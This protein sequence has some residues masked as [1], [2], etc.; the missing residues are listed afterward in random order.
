[1]PTPTLDDRLRAA[2]F[3]HVTKLQAAGGGLVTGEQLNKGMQFEGSRVPIWSEPRG[4]YKPALLGRHGAALTIVTT[5]PRPGRTP[6]YDDDV[7]SDNDYIIYRYR[8]TDPLAYDNRALRMAFAE[9]RPLLYLRGV[10]PGVYVPLFPVFIISD[11]PVHLTCHVS[12]G[13]PATVR[14]PLHTDLDATAMERAYQTVA[15]KKRLH[16]A[17]FRVLVLGAYEGRCAMCSLGHEELLDAA[18]ILADRDERGR[19]EVPNGLAPCKIHHTSFDTNI[20][21]IDPELRI[22]VREDILHEKDGPM[23]QFG[24]QAMAGKLIRVPRSPLMRP[25]AEYLDLR[26]AEFRAA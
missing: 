23:L 20:L 14:N 11:D 5:A 16:Q 17:R 7:G 9:C 18:H 1:M 25:K 4:I 19:P 24:L 15:A 22:H 2:L 21:G 6:P 10:R 3:A 26:F 12:V 8:G 13:L